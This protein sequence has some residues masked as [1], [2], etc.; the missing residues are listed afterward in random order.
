M[1]NHNLGNELVRLNQRDRA[2]TEYEQA[3]N[4]RRNLA[5]QN[6]TVPEHKSN[7]ADTHNSLGA[8]LVDLGQRDA[9]REQY[10]LAIQI[11][12]QLVAQFPAIAQH[13]VSLGGSYCNLGNLDVMCGHAAD[14]LPTYDSAIATLTPIHQAELRNVMAKEFLRNSYQGRAVALS[15]LKRHVE[16]IHDWDKVVDLSAPG[17]QPTFRERRVNSRL[18][19][20]QITEAITEAEELVQSSNWTGRQWYSFACVFAV[21]STKYEAKRHEYAD[22]AMDLLQRAANAGY[23]NVAH[24]KKDK[25]LDALRDR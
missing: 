9:G 19:A 20:G 17:K 5:K 10:A 15:G 8:L 3:L 23:E 13:A 2:R 24:M 25:D 12:R 18:Q 4:L 1:V 11:Q 21:G 7:L 16:A 14:S 6:P 22:R